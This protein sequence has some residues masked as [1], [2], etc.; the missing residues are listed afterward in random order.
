[1]GPLKL[2]TN[3]VLLNHGYT[4]IKSPTPVFLVYRYVYIYILLYIYIYL[5]IYVSIYLY[6]CIYMLMHAEKST[7]SM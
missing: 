7:G 4:K 1:M 6:I 2:R 3:P 5:F